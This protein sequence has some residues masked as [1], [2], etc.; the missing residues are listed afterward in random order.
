MNLNKNAIGLRIKQNKA[1]II[2]MYKKGDTLQDIANKYNA[3]V[4]T[5]HRY[6]C[7]WDIKVKRNTYKRRAKSVN[8]YKR[9]FSK[10]FLANR[11]EM[12]KKYGHKIKYFKRE[13]TKSEMDRIRSITKQGVI[14]I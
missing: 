4:S 12:T 14:V 1:N 5:I 13:D 2:A 7:R 9:N 10:E 6:L 3:A 8:K 11:A